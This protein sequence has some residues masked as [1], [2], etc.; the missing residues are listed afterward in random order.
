MTDLPA[1][2]D[3]KHLARHV[4]LSTRDINPDVNTGTTVA[5][6]ILA[7]NPT[8]CLD[9][10]KDKLQPAMHVDH[11]LAGYVTNDVAAGCAACH[12]RP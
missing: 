8:N 7:G 12:T 10:H 5:M 6:V 4:I 1:E 9:C 11:V 2:P 3:R